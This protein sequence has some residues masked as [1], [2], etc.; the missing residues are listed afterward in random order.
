MKAS[1]PD[2]AIDSTSSNYSIKNILILGA[3]IGV[4]FYLWTLNYNKLGSFSDYS[5]MADAAGKFRAGLRPFRD[6]S[7]AL[8]SL[9]IWLAHACEVLFGPRYLAL[10]YGNLLLTL[11]LFF[12]VVH[13]AKR[14]FT[15]PLA[16]LIAL[17]ICVA[18]TLQHGIIWYNSIAL[19]LLSAIS[20]KCAD[21][22]RSRT[23]SLRDVILVASL[24]LL[25]GMTKMNFYAIAIGMVIYFA[26][27]D[28]ISAPRARDGKK[29]AALA[30]L[31]VVV[32]AAPPF[33]ETFANH[34][35]MST[36]VREVILTPAS[37]RAGNLGRMF[38]LPFYLVEMNRWYPGTLLMGSV[39]FCLL[40]YG[41]LV[42]FAIAQFLADARRDFR[43]LIV[44]VGFISLFWG[45][46]SLLVLT[47]I[48]IE[49][50]SL[51]FCLV[52]V[53][54]MRISG[55]FSGDKW[56]KALQ[57]SAIVL[58]AYFSLVGS[59]SVARHSR[60]SFLANVFPGE[61]IPK[62]GEPAYFRGVNLSRQAVVEIKLI[63]DVLKKNSGVP[64]YWG[65]GL[66][67]MN[68]VQ[69][70]VTN[71]AFPLWYQRDITVRES[72]TPRLI[73]AIEESHAGLFVA[74]RFWYDFYYVFPEGLHS[75]LDREWV[76]EERDETLVVYRKRGG[77]NTTGMAG[78]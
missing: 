54:A 61:T 24:L 11:G 12:I 27:A 17:A 2:A 39:L 13:Y 76:L 41:F 6:Y 4:L 16:I 67:I 56:E 36:W 22:F 30:V 49:S 50:L 53:V 3:S 35:T 70:G 51:S 73:G 19:V 29:I 68:R 46:T 9:P 8:Q 31:G 55:Q 78:K 20:L 14:A 66:E 69:K 47:N 74:G 25:V 38:Y 21:L 15:F 59:V 1:F 65:P 62:D 72:D 7:S 40:V 42:Y 33:I 75:Y 37:A 18:S 77:Q 32:C 58:V 48:E 71:P 45:S 10:A 34:V 5:I 43:R 44:Q 52:G 57:S 28:V 60:I 63:N 64:V 23:V 26:L